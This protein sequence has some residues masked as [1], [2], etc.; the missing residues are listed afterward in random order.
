MFYNLRNGL[1]VAYAFSNPFPVLHGQPRRPDVQ[2]GRLNNLSA[3]SVTA[4]HCE[5]FET[6][7]GKVLFTHIC[8]M[9]SIYFLKDFL[10]FEMLLW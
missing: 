5:G 10:M 3:G 7:I 4:A 9:R 1:D 8:D 6:G 2:T